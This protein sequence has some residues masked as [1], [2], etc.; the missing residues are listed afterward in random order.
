[1]LTITISTDNA[2]F[3]LRSGGKR[4]ELARILRAMAQQLEDGERLR[5]PRDINGN[6]CG[7]VIGTGAERDLV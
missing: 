5:S 2:A 4:A 3:D 7:N 6:H 1:M